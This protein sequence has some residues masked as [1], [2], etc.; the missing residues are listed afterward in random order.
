MM[1]GSGERGMSP[2]GRRERGS[3]AVNWSSGS[4]RRSHMTVLRRRPLKRSAG[5]ASAASSASYH[6][7]CRPR[8]T[9]SAPPSAVRCSRVSERRQ[10][11]ARSAGALSGAIQRGSPSAG[12]PRDGGRESAA[13]QRRGEG[14]GVRWRAEKCE[15]ADGWYGGR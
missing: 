6:P 2:G 9:A 10:R 12:S 14:S 11:S 3:S 7:T 15:R 4:S 1:K 8:S 13:A 5:P